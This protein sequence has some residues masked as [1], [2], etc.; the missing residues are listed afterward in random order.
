[1][2]CVRL[3]TNPSLVFLSKKNPLASPSHP[4]RRP[5]FCASPPHT[6][7]HMEDWELVASPRAP[8]CESDAESAASSAAPVTS[9]ASDATAVAFTSAGSRR[10]PRLRKRGAAAGSEVRVEWGGRGGL[11]AARRCPQTA[12]PKRSRPRSWPP[13][14]GQVVCPHG[15]LGVAEQGGLAANDHT[16]N[17]HTAQRFVHPRLAR[18]HR[19]PP[20]P[21]VRVAATVVRVAT[22]SRRRRRRRR[23][24][25]RVCCARVDPACRGGR[26][27]GRRAA[28]AA[29]GV[30]SGGRGGCLMFVL[31]FVLIYC[32]VRSP[33][34]PLLMLQVLFLP[35]ISSYCFLQKHTKQGTSGEKKGGRAK[36]AGGRSTS[37]LL[38][39]F[40]HHCS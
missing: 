5:P 10:S 18:R 33:P 36:L 20:P 13:A 3:P 35:M 1:M 11:A 23:V 2:R 39:R 8:R 32:F 16:Q 17:T 4:L 29:G 40:Q 34:P 37:R 31:V 26:R 9:E 21:V 19:P 25:G 7:P 6:H 38:T 12:C 24:V 14:W 15:R 28:L 22:Q 30:R 27:A